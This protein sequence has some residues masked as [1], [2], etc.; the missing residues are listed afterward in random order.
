M[1]E[2]RKANIHPK[3]LSGWRQAVIDERKLTDYALKMDDAK[4]R[5]KA[6]AFRDALG[7]TLVNYKTLVDDVL[8]NLCR[9][10]AKS[11]GNQIYGCLYEVVMPITG[12]NG[13]T[14]R[15]LTAWIIEWGNEVPRLTSIYVTK[16]RVIL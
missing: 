7:Y 8:N 6:V 11:K 1:A 10:P 5:D 2:R 13:R 9:Y 4:S 3:A 16:K 12:P 15:V 14:A